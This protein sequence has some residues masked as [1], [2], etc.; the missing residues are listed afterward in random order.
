MHVLIFQSEDMVKLCL[1]FNKFQPIYTYKYYAFKKECKSMCIKSYINIIGALRII[2][3]I[4][5]EGLSL[6]F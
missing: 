4:K 6:K 5:I 2:L 1:N 3:E